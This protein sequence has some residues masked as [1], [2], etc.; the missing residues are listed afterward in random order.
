MTPT[1]VFRLAAL[2]GGARIEA[3]RRYGLSETQLLQQL[4]HLLEDPAVERDHPV[5]V[6]RWRRILAGQRAARSRVRL[7]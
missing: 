7:R 6:H 1:I 2:S 4:R 5:D 3:C